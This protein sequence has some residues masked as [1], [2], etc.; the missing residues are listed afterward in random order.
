MAI[1]TFTFT[2]EPIGTGDEVPVI[3]NW[4]P[5]VPYSAKQT[6]I[7]ALYYFK[8]ILD[9]RIGSSGGTLIARLKQRI[10]GLNT[11]V[12]V[13]AVFD[14]KEI[15][16]SVL[17]P[18]TTDYNIVVNAVNT[19]PIH[20]L[21]ANDG[22]TK[23]FSLNALQLRSIY[24]KGYQE[25]SSSATDSPTSHDATSDN[26]TRFY[27]AATLPLETKRGTDNF[28]SGTTAAGDFGQF[29]L[30]G[31]AGKLLSDVQKGYDGTVGASV[32]YNKVRS[33]D[34]HTV[35]FLNSFDDF[36]SEANLFRIRYYNAAGTNLTSS[37]GN[38]YE[39]IDNITGNGGK[40][41]ATGTSLS[42]SEMLLYF[43]CG[44]ANLEAQTANT[45]ARP[46]DGGYS[47][48]AYYF[49][50]GCKTGGSGRSAKYYFI[51]DDDN[52][53]G[54]KVRRLGWL[55]NVGC[56]DYFNFKMKSRQTVNVKRNEYST[57]LGEFNKEMYS[58]NNF[59][60]GR[61]TRKIDAT[62]TETINTDW[63]T[64]SEATLL[65]SLIISN[66]VYVIENDDTT[67]TVPIIIKDT[68]YIRKT[69]ANDKLMRYTITIEYA[70]PLNT[71]S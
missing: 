33:T 7:S 68:R 42:D 47:G 63:L 30:D 37:D 38:L 51:K 35:G 57:M 4:T 31:S 71:N 64:E 1:G 13:A 21:A 22:S 45:Y 65:E 52:C 50:E 14:V 55:N 53:K 34:Y 70:N 54:F 11:T 46:S 17:E 12:N 44:P 19:M 18:Q 23:P 8:F 49:V 5:V 67:Y 39:D 9:V 24:V 66:D 41:P 43:G 28:Q 62:L 27:M 3:T 48:W 56:W 16:N 26:D 32:Y 15:I 40:T 36:D 29:Q 20:K 58:Y 25:F 2:Q 60:R 69:I 10:N 6:D 59:G 61:K